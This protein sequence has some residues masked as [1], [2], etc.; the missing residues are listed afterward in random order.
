MS[1]T[2]NIDG[3]EWDSLSSDLPVSIAK[4]REEA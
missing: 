1:V 3:K 4:G 2:F